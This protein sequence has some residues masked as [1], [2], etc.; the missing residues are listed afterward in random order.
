MDM[1]LKICLLQTFIQKEPFEELLP[2]IDA[3]NKD[4]QSLLKVYKNLITGK[5][6]PVKQTVET[7]QRSYHDKSPRLSS[8]MNDSEEE[9][10][11]I[12]RWLSSMRRI[13]PHLTRYFPN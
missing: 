4:I 13:Y 5:L 2:Y 6:A 11:Q 10:E 7:A 8:Q 12:A 3:M 1:V 9:I